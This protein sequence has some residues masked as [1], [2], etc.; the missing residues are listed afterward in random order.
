MFLGAFNENSAYYEAKEGR[1]GTLEKPGWSMV[2][3]EYRKKLSKPVTLK[4]LQKYSKDGGV[5]ANMQE[6]RAARLSV[7]KVSEDE[8]NFIV[9]QLIEGYE[10]DEI[11][12]GFALPNGEKSTTKSKKTKSKVNTPVNGSSD[13]I[14]QGTIDDVD[15]SDANTIKES[16]EVPTAA[17]E[18]P[19]STDPLIASEATVGS[20]AGS[21]ARKPSSRASSLAPAAPGSRAQSRGRTRSRASSVQPGANGGGEGEK[22][23]VIPE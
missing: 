3:V 17:L 4:E 15:M 2:H 16:T 1:R 20:R 23:D 6:F 5:L 10:E 8:W 11:G 12:S 22:M 9:N 7:S 13:S 14:V 18:I 19:T 21:K